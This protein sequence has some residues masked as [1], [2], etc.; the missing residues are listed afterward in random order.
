M[1]KILYILVPALAGLALAACGQI[2]PV[3][4]APANG[5]L[6]TIHVSIPKDATRVEFTPD[7]DGLHLA[8][9]DDDCLRVI[10]D[11]DNGLFTIKDDFDDQDAEFIGPAVAGLSFDIIYPGTC[12][13]VEE[14]EAALADPLTQNGNGNTSHLCYYTCLKGVDSYQDIVFSKSWAEEHGGEF[15][16]P[17]IA[18]LVLTMPEGVTKLSKVSLT[19][20]DDTYDLSLRNVD[21]S[22]SDQVLTAYILLPWE[23]ISLDASSTVSISVIDNNEAEYGISITLTEAK[24]IKAGVVSNFKIASGIEEAKFAGGTGIEADPYLIANGKHLENMM[25][26]YKDG[27]EDWMKYFKMIDDVDATGIEWAPLNYLDPYK[28]G[29]NFDGNGHTISNLEVGGDRKYASFAGVLYGTIKD[30]T[31][32]GATIDGGSQKSGVVCGYLG[33][34]TIVGNC[35]GVTVKNST[36]SSSDFC[37]GFVAQANSAGTV[38]D[39]HVVNTKVIQKN[40]TADAQKSTGGFVGHITAAASFSG[41][42]AQVVIESSTPKKSGVGGFA[43]KTHNVAPSFENCKVLS[44]SSVTADGNWIGGFVGFA[45]GGGTFDTCSTAADVKVTSNGQFAG[46][47]VGYAQNAAGKYTDCSAS[48]SVVAPVNVGGFSGNADAGTFK[49]CHY[50]GKSVEGTNTSGNAMVGGFDGLI[51]GSGVVF[52]E[53][54]VY[55]A[56]GVTIS[57]HT[58]RVGGFFGQNSKNGTS[59]YSTA[60]KC[61][62]KNATV[63]GGGNN[64]GGFVGVQYSDIS[65]SWVQDVTVIA[66]GANTAA[67]SAFVNNAAMTD[68][69]ALNVTVD[70]GA[71]DTAGGLT[72]ICNA[73]SN[74]KNSFFSGDVTGSGSVLGGLAG[75]IANAAVTF[76]GCISWNATLPMA[77]SNANS[78]DLTDN[79]AGTTGTISEHASGFGWDTAIWNLSGATPVLY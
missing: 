68:C 36:V 35:S 56:D 62:V 40:T 42:T 66:G 20:G 30:V 54:Y 79:Y 61:Y 71:F 49:R 75:S 39:C 53:C 60:T 58:Q 18:K 12:E 50:D 3:E 23:D 74:I 59:G 28:Q 41:C 25:L 77:G 67:I 46:G 45:Q 17:G 22:N 11:S 43:G 9:E 69:Y 78:V 65:K 5:E 55:N 26:M 4:P 1:K 32:D 2:E 13:S 44:G 37:G 38:T 24:T 72:G 19:L 64:T 52:E 34:G 21:V 16:R 7:G 73:N 8:W 33:T 27:T 31:F 15:L 76:S 51:G 29:I 48:G 14:V 57:G 6:T 70:A 63:K 47:F 10:S